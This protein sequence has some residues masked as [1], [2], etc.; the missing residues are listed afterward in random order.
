MT[1]FTKIQL[2][3]YCVLVVLVSLGIS[4]FIEGY[5]KII[6]K[7]KASKYEIYALSFLLS[8]LATLGLIYTHLFVPVLVFFF[9]TSFWLDYIFL[10]IVIY[11]IQYLIDMKGIKALIKTAAVQLISKKCSFLSKEDISKLFKD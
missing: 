1:D 10:C 3:I 7:D 5:K 4:V 2:I 6:R 9:S 8:I 11:F